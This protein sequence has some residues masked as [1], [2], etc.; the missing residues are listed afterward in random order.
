MLISRVPTSN[1]HIKYF[2]YASIVK[3]VR[4][5]CPTCW[6]RLDEVEQEHQTAGRNGWT[7]F[8]LSST[9]R[10][11]REKRLLWWQEWK[12]NGSLT[13][14]FFALSCPGLACGKEWLSVCEATRRAWIWATLQNHLKTFSYPLSAYVSISCTH[15]LHVLGPLQLH[16]TIS[17]S[18]RFDTSS[19]LIYRDVN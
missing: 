10:S 18:V 15:S 13:L 3:P 8:D 7:R 4:A 1:W 19:H 9:I 5:T 2:T 17:S 16:L 14:L 6:S 12:E 11:A